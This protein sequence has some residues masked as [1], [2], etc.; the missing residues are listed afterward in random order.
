M[1]KGEVYTEMGISVQPDAFPY[2]PGD[3]NAIFNKSRNV[4]AEAS[5]IASHRIG[6]FRYAHMAILF[7]QVL[8]FFCVAFLSVVVIRKGGSA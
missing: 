1:D 3:I 6:K 2:S 5:L 7:S 8:F 4:Q